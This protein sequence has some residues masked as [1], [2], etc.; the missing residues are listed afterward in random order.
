[1][2][3]RCADGREIWVSSTI[4]EMHYEGIGKVWVGV[5]SDIS[6]RRQAQ[7]ARDQAI[8]QLQRLS[9]SVQD[10]IEAERIAL[11]R[12]LHDQLGAS[13]I[14]MHMQLEALSVKLQA[15]S[16][17]LARDA[18]AIIAQARQ[19]QRDARDIC[20]RL[21]PALLD[22]MGLT[23]ACRWYAKEWSRLSG[24]AVKTRFT[25]LALEPGPNIATDMFRVLQELLTNVARHAQAG[26]V[27]IALRSDERLLVLRVEDN[28]G[29]FATEAI[30]EG[31]GLLGIRERLRRHG[32]VL[33]LRSGAGGSRITATM[34]LKAHP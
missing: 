21:R 31:F 24:I 34:Q 30:T 13:L 26:T 33:H 6:E 29:G 25:A 4:T 23:E 17:A 9:H 28:G 2:K 32:G 20:S 27:R 16:P 1:L 15:V 14:G 11:S 7:A 18:L 19:T 12:E 5:N 8:V 10:Q 22:D 3:N